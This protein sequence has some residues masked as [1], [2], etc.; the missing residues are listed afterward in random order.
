MPIR[1]RSVEDFAKEAGGKKK[2]LELLKKQNIR[3]LDGYFDERRLEAAL[4]EPAWLKDRRREWNLS[5]TSGLGAIKQLLDPLKVDIVEH[6]CRGSQWLTLQREKQNKPRRST[7][8]VYYKGGLSN[9][10]RGTKVR[11][12]IWNFLRDDAPDYY[13]CM[14]FEG[15][16]AWVLDPQELAQRWATIQYAA[17]P[18]FYRD[19]NGFFIPF[20]SLDHEGGHLAVS[21]SINDTR[22]GLNA[23][24]QLGL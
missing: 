2:A 14:C 9:G 23:A 3:V 24:S 18:G 1:L 16:R 7:V 13:L 12:D 8:K 6:E 11:F 5:P 15:P 4:S 22:L 20:N 19:D 10:N 21:L 17:N